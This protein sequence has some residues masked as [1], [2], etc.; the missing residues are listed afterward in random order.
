MPTP[1]AVHPV[2]PLLTNMSVGF[3]QDLG[4]FVA[5]RVFP[6][7]PVLTNSGTFATYPKGSLWRDEL[8]PRPLGGELPRADYEVGT[9]TYTVDEWGVKEHVDARTIA[10][11]LSPF[12]PIEDATWHLSMM[13]AI[14]AERR[15][16][17]AFIGTPIWGTDIQGVAATPTAGTSVLQWNDAS[18]TPAHDIRYL[19]NLV[20]GATGFKPQVLVVGAD[21]WLYLQNSAEIKEIIKYTQTGIINEAIVAAAM[22]IEELIVARGI[23]NSAAEGAADSITRIVTADAGVLLYRTP[24]PGLRT[25]T[26]GSTFAWQGLVP[27]ATNILGGVIERGQD[28]GPVGTYSEVVGIRNAFSYKLVSSD[29]GVYL[30]DLIA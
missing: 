30:Y 5:G 12:Q 29:L 17:T 13:A 15:W 18:A 22:G 26:A 19:C 14:N 27:G 10:N 1:K 9:D 11:A 6:V 25:P 16:A 23:Y 20:D 2:D 7:V 4:A 21:A 8:A 24:R 28:P 3:Q